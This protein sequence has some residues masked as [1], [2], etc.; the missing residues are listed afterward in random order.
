MTKPN[1][2]YQLILVESYLPE[3]TSGLHGKVHIRPL[4]NQGFSTALHVECSKDLA[5]KFPVGTIFRI[6]AKLTDYKEGGEFLYSNY[7]WKFEVIES[8]KN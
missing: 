1:E 3:K 7:N 5:T 6:K 2:S 4:Q 8:R